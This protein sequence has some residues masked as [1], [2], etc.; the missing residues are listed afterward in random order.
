MGSWP[1]PGRGRRR[2]LDRPA[3]ASVAVDNRRP[4]ARGELLD[5]GEEA[6]G[7]M[8]APARGRELVL[9]TTL[10]DAKGGLAVAAA[11][12]VAASSGRPVVLLAEL[13]AGGGRG[14]TMLAAASAR[15]L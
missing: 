6:G 4:S 1:K 11:M 13:G 10:G 7:M 3:R 14:P 15:E 2:A 8:G 12:G 5:L 9:A